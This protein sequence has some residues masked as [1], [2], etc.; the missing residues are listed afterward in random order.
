MSV[1]QV[2]E[3]VLAIADSPWPHTAGERAGVGVCD[4]FQTE[5]E[6]VSSGLPSQ[7]RARTGFSIGSGSATVAQSVGQP[8]TP[9]GGADRLVTVGK[10]ATI[11]ARYADGTREPLGTWRVANA[12]GGLTSNS[13]NVPLSESQYGSPY[14]TMPTPVGAFDPAWI[15]DVLARQLGNYSTPKPAPSC[16]LSIPGV[17]GL[18]A[19]YG[20]FSYTDGV[21]EPV[22]IDG[23]A[24]LSGRTFITTLADGTTY[25]TFTGEAC[26]FTVFGEM[27]FIG[28]QSISCATGD[29]AYFA[30]GLDPVDPLRIQ[31]EI[32][33]DLPRVQ[34]RAR[35]SHD[36]AWSSPIEMN[37]AAIQFDSRFAQVAG[38]FRGLQLTRD[39]DPELWATPT[40][41]I[42]LLDAACLAP[43]L[44]PN[45]RVWEALQETVQAFLG[46][47][48]IDRAGVLRAKSRHQ[49]AGLGRREKVID[50]ATDADSLNWTISADDFADRMEI[51][52]SRLDPDEDTDE[53]TVGEK[54][55]VRANAS[56][57][58]L[59][60]L[61]TFV[62]TVNGFAH[63]D[64]ATSNESTWEANDAPLGDGA[65]ITS[66]LA[67]KIERITGST[68]R[69]TVTNAN[70]FDV[71]LVD[72]TGEP[73]VVVRGSD[74]LKSTMQ[75][76]IEMGVSVGESV[77][78]ISIKLGPLV[79]SEAVANALVAYLWDRCQTPRWRAESIRIRPDLQLDIGAVIALTHTPTGLRTD[80]LVTRVQMSGKSGEFAQHIDLAILPPTVS[81]FDASWAGATCTAFDTALAGKT[82]SDFDAA[83][84]RWR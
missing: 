60:E 45:L 8:L 73:A 4:S 53:W 15:V 16:I 1:E 61:A 47:C 58:F 54:I 63:A 2:P 10:P 66:G 79:Q 29:S 65:F 26:T 24:A 11:E 69:V 21:F 19:E 52:W 84:M 57:V 28:S 59:V 25:L 17:G 70:G 31:L 46:A 20:S 81:A 62:G 77:E 83:P 44:S 43:V 14:A 71:W 56:A 12:A 80:A 22:S 5:R 50:V 23:Q 13:L 64:L 9:Y 68:A 30:R 7:I 6:I 38:D 37:L 72:D 27:L 55:R 74:V 51:E 75:P 40:A 3:I 41:D 39:A 67:F 76:Q 32:R 18:H 33:T 82:V 48:W 35:S 36:A 78:P 49:L 42:P 34:V